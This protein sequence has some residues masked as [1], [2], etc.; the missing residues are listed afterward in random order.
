MSE[1]V[2]YLHGQPKPVGRF[3]RI[4]STG[5][6]QLETLHGSGKLHVDRVVVEAS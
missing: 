4:G 2:V 3:L 1:N 6:R 5:H